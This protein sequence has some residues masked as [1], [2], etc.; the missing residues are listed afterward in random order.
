MNQVYIGNMVHFRT[1]TQNF[2]SKKMI[3]KPEDDWVVVEGTHEALVDAETF[4][5]VQERIKVKQPGKKRSENNIFRGIMFCGEC[6]KRMAFCS[7]KKDERGKSLGT[8]SCNANRRYG[9][10]VCTTHYISLEQV[11]AIVLA[12]IRR[13]A[14]LVAED[15]DAYADYLMSLSQT[16]QLSEQK[17]MKK[18]WTQ[19]SAACPNWPR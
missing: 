18:N 7:R 11:K 19:P 13:H 12:D 17:A 8:F 3:W 5:T 9:G 1:G 16:G 4:W 14:M 2:K 6:G 10:K 15:A